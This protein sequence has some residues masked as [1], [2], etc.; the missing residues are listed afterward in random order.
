VNE[1]LSFFKEGAKVGAIQD[2]TLAE[3]YGYVTIGT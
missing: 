3:L 1:L 2:K